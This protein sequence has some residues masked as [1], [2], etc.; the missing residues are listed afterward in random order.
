MRD[1]EVCLQ[2]LEQD[3]E[4]AQARSSVMVDRTEHERVLLLLQVQGLIAQRQL[5]HANISEI[6]S[7]TP[8]LSIVQRTQRELAETRATL[9]TA[10]TPAAAAIAPPAA[11]DASGLGHLNPPVDSLGVGSSSNESIDEHGSVRS[12]WGNRDASYSHEIQNLIRNLPVAVVAA[13]AVGVP[14]GAA[15]AAAVLIHCSA[16]KAQFSR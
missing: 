8:R 10:T 4:T 1:L 5:L 3:L 2:F 13:L 11:M 7:F 15:A 12:C 16:I 14:A 9:A 6:H